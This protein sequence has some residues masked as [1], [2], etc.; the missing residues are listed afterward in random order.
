[1]AKKTEM[2]ED[3]KKLSVELGVDSVDGLTEKGAREL[4]DILADPDKKQ[5]TDSFFG[6][7]FKELEKKIEKRKKA[8]ED[9]IMDLQSQKY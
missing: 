4:S 5:Y 7:F 6:N 1:M 2:I 8:L 9:A 3:I